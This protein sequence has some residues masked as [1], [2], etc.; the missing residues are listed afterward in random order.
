[1]KPKGEYKD[2]PIQIKSEG[3]KI[4][5]TQAKQENYDSKEIS[6]SDLDDNKED[7]LPL[8]LIMTYIQMSEE[9]CH[10]NAHHVVANFN[11]EMQPATLAAMSP[12]WKVLKLRSNY[13]S[14]LQRFGG[15][16][17]SNVAHQYFKEDNFSL[18]GF[19]H[20]KQ[21][22]LYHI[23]SAS[24]ASSDPSSTLDAILVINVQKLCKNNGVNSGIIKAANQITILFIMAFTCSSQG[25]YN[26]PSFQ[27]KFLDMNLD[28]KVPFGGK[29]IVVIHDNFIRAYGLDAANMTDPVDITGPSKIMESFIWDP[30]PISYC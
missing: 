19:D 7:P 14:K 30:G 29:S 8:V 3:A 9:A 17:A 18:D 28:D 2:I 16:R 12:E 25:I 13:K 26:T 1:M 24:G 22:F 23:S 6:N 27:M 10:Y 5:L 21:Y 4:L 15:E 11:R 20:V